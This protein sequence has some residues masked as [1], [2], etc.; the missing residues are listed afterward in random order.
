MIKIIFLV[1]FTFTLNHYAISNETNCDE[2]K[3][4]SSE[5]FNCKTEIIKDKAISF[6][7]N[8]V[9]DTKEYQKKNYEDGKKQIE[10]TKKQIEKTGE[11]V[12]KK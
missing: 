5:Y 10:N 7:K 12:L 3:K 4:Y 9:E 1:L 8:F 2:F 6:G 11:K